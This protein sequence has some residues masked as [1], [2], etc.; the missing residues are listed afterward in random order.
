MHDRLFEHRL[1]LADD[2]LRDHAEAIGVAD[3]ERFAADLRDRVHAARVEADLR[4]GARSGVPSTPR[5]FVNGVIHLGSPSYVELADAI[6]SEL[7]V[8]LA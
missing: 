2:D 4:S 7:N 6:G 3:G 8:T 1:E 5:F